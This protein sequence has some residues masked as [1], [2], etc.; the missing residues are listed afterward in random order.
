MGQE[1]KA[2]LLM[3]EETQKPAPEPVPEPEKRVQ[4]KCIYGNKVQLKNLSTGE[5]TEYHLVTYSEERLK[6]NYI[7]NYTPVGRAI[8]AKH[9]GDE[10]EIEGPGPG[11][12]RYKII[13]I[14][15]D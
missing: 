15:N 3:V 13:L 1:M 8:W 2:N 10:V 11:K 5:I 6:K 7:S 9:E 14:E 4:L 12:N